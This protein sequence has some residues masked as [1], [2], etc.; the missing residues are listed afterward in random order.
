[1]SCYAGQFDQ[2][3]GLTVNVAEA[4]NSAG[5]SFLSEDGKKVTV[6]SPE[7]R[8]GLQHLVDMFK[9]G[10]ID[11]AAI[12]YKEQESANAFLDGKALFL[13]NWPYVYTAASAATRRSPASSA[14]RSCPVRRARACPPSAASTS[15]SR[16]SRSTRRPPRRG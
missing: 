3:E 15:A 14:W 16:P 5:G 9:N 8:A 10:D 13:R 11:P 1:M 12:T 7:A 2:Y 4:I 6:D